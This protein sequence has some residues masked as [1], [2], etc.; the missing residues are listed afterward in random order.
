MSNNNL[1]HISDKASSVTFDPTGTDWPADVL[2]VQTAIGKISGYA[3]KDKGLPKASRS[4]DGVVKLGTIDEVKAGVDDEKAVTPKVLNE[5]LQKPHATDQAYGTTKYATNAEAIDDSNNSVS[6]TPL[7]LDFVFKNKPATESRF[8]ACKLATRSQAESGTEDNVVMTPLKVK[9]AIDKLVAASGDAT[10]TSRGVVKLATAAEI[11]AGQA[12]QGVAISPLG[13]AKARGTNSAYGTF[14]AAQPADMNALTAQD[15]AV[16]PWV[17]GQTKGGTNQFGLVKLATDYTTQGNTALSA[18][19][20]VMFKSG[21][22]FAGDIFRGS[23]AAGN[24]YIT[25]T[26]AYDAM[27]VGS[28]I[29][30]IGANMPNSNWCVLDGRRLSKTTYSRLFNVIGTRFGG[31][32]NSFNIMDMRGMFPRG[33]DGGRGQDPGRGLGTYQRCQAEAHQHI[34]GG[35]GE[36]YG[37]HYFGQTG[38]KNYAGSKGGQDWDNYI[39]YTSNGMDNWDGNRI[40][41]SSQI[42][43]ETRPHNMAVYFIIKIN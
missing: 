22:V 9:F 26:E 12:A 37:N 23:N 14:K 19:A 20:N 33:V 28:V 21:G 18:N 38:K 15:K 24:R 3:N 42:G 17:L 43:N 31:D 8:G 34:G 39:M 35:L 10:E 36:A 25:Q 1:S 6:I 16:T 5:Y 27:P 41:T 29:M 30:W 13:F 7:S 2:D 11:A 32:A 40:N 4:V